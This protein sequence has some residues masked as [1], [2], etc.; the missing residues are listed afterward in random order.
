MFFLKDHKTNLDENSTE[1]QCDSLMAH[2]D[3][4]GAQNEPPYKVIEGKFM[5]II[6]TVTSCRNDQSTHG[7][8]PHAHLGDGRIHLMLVRKTSRIGFLKFL[9]SLSKD[10]VRPGKLKYVDI[11]DATAVRI[12]PMD[13][14]SVWNVDGELLLDQELST[15]VRCRLLQVFSRGI[16]I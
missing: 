10:G 5:S 16:E 4:E 12:E 7:V 11:V 13:G 6:V 14:K 2:Q 9:L 8:T 3:V 1:S 15:N